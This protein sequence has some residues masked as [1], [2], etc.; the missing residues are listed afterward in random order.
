MIATVQ[1]RAEEAVST[2]DSGMDELEE[3]LKLAMD[4][5]SDKQEVQAILERLFATIDELAAATRT[6]GNRIEAMAESADT[7]RTA[8]Q[9]S[10]RSAEQTGGAAQALNR[11]MAQFKV[12]AAAR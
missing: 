7:V 6:N 11:L 2:M 5:A 10:H 3:G 8:I 4:A 12:S 9:E 1:N